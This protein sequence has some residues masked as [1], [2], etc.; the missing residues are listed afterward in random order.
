MKIKLTGFALAALALSGCSSLNV[1]MTDVYEVH[2]SGFGNDRMKYTLQSQ[3]D[4]FHHQTRIT[5]N[6]SVSGVCVVRSDTL[7][8][9][10]RTDE[11]VAGNSAT[12][13][14]SPRDIRYCVES[15]VEARPC[16]PVDKNGNSSSPS[17]VRREDFR[18]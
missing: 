2:H 11:L 18:R 16:S 17:M 4:G 10:V 3:R 9:G 7:W 8:D 15:K 5:C 6:S 1:S 12:L 14:L 13:E